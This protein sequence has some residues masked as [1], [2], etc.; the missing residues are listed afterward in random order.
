MLEVD[1][2]LE[3]MSRALFCSEH[4]PRWL[5]KTETPLEFGSKVEMASE[6]IKKRV[7]SD[8]CHAA[9][10]ALATSQFCFISKGD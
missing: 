7:L 5:E 10:R 2:G 1:R 8:S 3:T 6:A 4:F 9:K